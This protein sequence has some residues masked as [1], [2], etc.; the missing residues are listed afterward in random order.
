MRIAMLL[1]PLLLVSSSMYA[2]GERDREILEQLYT[3]NRLLS[4][5]SDRLSEVI[6]DL[7]ALLA[8]QLIMGSYQIERGGSVGRQD[9]PLGPFGQKEAKLQHDKNEV[10]L[11]TLCV[12]SLGQA[13]RMLPATYEPDDD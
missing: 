7:R 2:V 9:N 13:V 8:T 4:H 3:S 10:D 12:Q 6:I 5:I 1:F 11:H